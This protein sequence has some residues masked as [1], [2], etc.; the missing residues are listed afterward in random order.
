MLNSIYRHI[1]WLNRENWLIIDDRHR[2]RQAATEHCRSL[3]DCP[4]EHDCADWTANGRAAAAVWSAGNYTWRCGPTRSRR[5]VC[6]PPPADSQRVGRKMAAVTTS[7]MVAPAKSQVI[8][9]PRRN[10]AESPGRRRQASRAAVFRTSA[11]TWEHRPSHSLIG[12]TRLRNRMML[13]RI[14]VTSLWR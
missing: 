11:C 2:S 13:T 10:A 12:Y 8:G 1:R 6:R 9:S 7:A 3:T 14:S 4:A 5:V